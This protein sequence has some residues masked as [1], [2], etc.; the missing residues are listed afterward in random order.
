MDD[1]A[2]RG[3]GPGASLDTR[4]R[5]SLSHKNAA[6]AAAAAAAVFAATRLESERLAIR[7]ALE[8]DA[9]RGPGRTGRMH[10][11]SSYTR[12]TRPSHSRED[13]AVLAATRQG[14]AL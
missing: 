12:T 9:A 14:G 11:A 7:G 10:G 4:E 1:A 8:Y 5:P 3:Q 6:A 2:V 13:A